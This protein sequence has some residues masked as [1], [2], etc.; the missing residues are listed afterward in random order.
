MA[1]PNAVINENKSTPITAGKFSVEP[2]QLLGCEMKH[3]ASQ[4]PNLV[5]ILYYYGRS[6]IWFLSTLNIR[7]FVW[8]LVGLVDSLDMSML[9][10]CVNFFEQFCEEI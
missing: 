4:N 2:N 9:D 1:V 6:L 8:D 7:V 5:S 10:L 3:K